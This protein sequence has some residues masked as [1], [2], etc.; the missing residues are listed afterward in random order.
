MFDAKEEEI[1]DIYDLFPKKILI[2]YGGRKESFR[3]K[4]ASA[5]LD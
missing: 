4:L 2:I 5:T 3:D 1:K